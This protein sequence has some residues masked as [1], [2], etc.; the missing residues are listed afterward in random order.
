M[1]TQHIVDGTP[2]HA[3]PYMYTPPSTALNRIQYHRHEELSSFVWFF[4]KKKYTNF[5]IIDF[6]KN[7][8]KM[9]FQHSTVNWPL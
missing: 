9:H 6:W 8:K 5:L 3:F 2:G 1:L 4:K 7:D